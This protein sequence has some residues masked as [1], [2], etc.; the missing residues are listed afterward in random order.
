MLSLQ[1]SRAAPFGSVITLR[2]SVF[3]FI[4]SG[5]FTLPIN[6]KTLTHSLLQPAPKS[7]VAH[8]VLR[9]LWLYRRPTISF[10]FDTSRFILQFQVCSSSPPGS[11]P[12]LY[13]F[14]LLR[15]SKSLTFHLSTSFNDFFPAFYTEKKQ[16]DLY[17]LSL[18]PSRAALFGPCRCP[19]LFCI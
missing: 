18:Q 7:L 17:A 8:R 5:S 4:Y 14:A 10:V 15:V 13:K 11:A 1:P 9:A 19:I 6:L 2:F 16:R 12:G 3:V